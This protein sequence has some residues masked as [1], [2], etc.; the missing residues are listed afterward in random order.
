MQI[1]NGLATLAFVLVG[2]AVGL[3]LLWL[4]RRTGQLPELAIGAALLVISAVGY[5]LVILS[6][7]PGVVA[8]AK[9]LR[10]MVAGTVAMNAGFVLLL[11]FTWSVFRR[12]AAWARAL[13]G[14]M[15]VAYLVHAVGNA[16]V[17]LG[18]DSPSQMM[19]GNRTWMIVGQLLNAITFGWVMVEGLRYWT[20]LR[21]RLALGIGDPVTT[22]R[23]FLWGFGGLC[24]MGTNLV[25]SWGILRQVDFFQAPGLQAA[26]ALLAVASCI[27]QYLAFLPPRAYVERLR[28]RHEAAA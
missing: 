22:N 26:V 25:S 6:G 27:A 11:L 18:L 28:R 24:S 23:F 10:M 8:P 3:R 15:G 2:T 9:G 1:V 13:V 4:A 21:R 5:P 20:M 17:M 12:D 19:T 16:T 7:A 14:A